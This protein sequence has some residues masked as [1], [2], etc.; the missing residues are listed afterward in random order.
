MRLIDA[1]ELLRNEKINTFA[2]VE[3]VAEAPT[4]DAVQVVRCKDCIY[5]EDKTCYT[6]LGLF[7]MVKPWD[8]CP[9]GERGEQ[10]E[11]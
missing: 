1:D 9:Y 6:K 10:V 5:Y 3:A 8:F 11:Q 4:I 7:G 2:A